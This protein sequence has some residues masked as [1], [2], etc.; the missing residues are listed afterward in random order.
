MLL[1]YLESWPTAGVSTNS[2]ITCMTEMKSQFFQPLQTFLK[3]EGHPLKQ[4]ITSNE[5][6][7]DA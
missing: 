4:Q 3:S 5:H 2:S 1:E 7:K 6:K